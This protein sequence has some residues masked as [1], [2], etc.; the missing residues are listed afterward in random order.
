ML[1]EAV[2]KPEIR[3]EVFESSLFSELN[4]SVHE[5]LLSAFE[6]DFSEEDWQHSF[7]GVRLIGFMNEE[8]VAHGAVVPRV[9]RIDDVEEK[10]GYV[11]AI[12][13]D[14]RFWR[15]GIGTALMEEITKIC[16][17]QYQF[18]MLSTGEKDFYRRFGWVDFKGE[19][20]VDLGEKVVRSE[21]EDEGL[22]YLG[23]GNYLNVS[24]LKVICK[25]RP[26]DAW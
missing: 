14:P 23:V 2:L 21:E 25:S 1:K 6:G 5:L 22:M 16:K 19:S 11:E 13:V 10:I 7:G 20:Y 17:S 4:I 9:V 3:F 8:I 26:G 12:A 24:P 15:Q 18:S